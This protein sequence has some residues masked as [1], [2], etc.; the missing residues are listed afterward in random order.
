MLLWQGYYSGGLTLLNTYI[1]FDFCVTSH[2]LGRQLLVPHRIELIPHRNVVNWMFDNA[3]VEIKT[4]FSEKD[5]FI[6]RIILVQRHNFYTKHEQ[7]TH[8]PAIQLLFF[9]AGLK[10]SHS[11][12]FSSSFWNR[13]RLRRWDCL[14]PSFHRISRWSVEHVTKPFSPKLVNICREDGNNNNMAVRS[15]PLKVFVPVRHR[16]WTAPECPI[17][18]PVNSSIFR[19]GMS[20]AF[21]DAGPVCLLDRPRVHIPKKPGGVKNSGLDGRCVCVYACWWV[22][23]CHQVRLVL[24]PEASPESPTSS[25]CRLQSRTSVRCNGG[26]HQRLRYSNHST[27]RWRMFYSITCQI[28]AWCVRHLSRGRPSCRPPPPSSGRCT[29][30]GRS[31]RLRG[32]TENT[33]FLVLFTSFSTSLTTFQF[34][35]SH[36]SIGAQVLNRHLT[37]FGS[38]QSNFRVRRRLWLLPQDVLVRQVAP[39]NRVP[40]DQ[41]ACVGAAGEQPVWGREGACVSD[42]GR[43][44]EEASEW[45]LPLWPLWLLANWPLTLMRDRIW[46]WW[47]DRQRISA[48][49][50]EESVETVNL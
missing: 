34:R 42:A 7:Q 31:P 45:E 19:L 38:V 40:Q 26:R 32:C 16:T 48:T 44:P 49:D 30:T 14:C 50:I 47:S 20:A 33:Q 43:A 21:F 2:T 15:P 5:I 4:L 37:R 27:D 22:C 1:L 41:L 29:R 6:G 36:F 12:P 17:R 23:V 28:T 35:P 9:K 18:S 25:R 10:K 11:P 8:K 39:V 3:R 13:A 24:Q 46:S